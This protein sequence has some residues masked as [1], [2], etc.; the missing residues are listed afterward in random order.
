[1]NTY[2][3]KTFC[4][5][6]LTVVGIHSMGAM[7]K[8]TQK[9]KVRAKRITK[10]S[11]AKRR[12]TG[13]EK[14]TLLDTVEANPHILGNILE[15]LP[16][17]SHHTLACTCRQMNGLIMGKRDG[18]TSKEIALEG[19]LK[20]II[21]EQFDPIGYTLEQAQG[22]P[23]VTLYGYRVKTAALVGRLLNM[24]EC[25]SRV[26]IDYTQIDTDRHH[27]PLYPIALN[28]LPIPEGVTLDTNEQL[29]CR[30]RIWVQN[31]H[32]P[33]NARKE[34]A[35][36]RTPG[37]SSVDKIHSW[38]PAPTLMQACSTHPEASVH[39]QFDNC[40][41]SA[42]T[43]DGCKNFPI[44]SI[45]FRHCRFEEN[46]LAC[47][48]Q[49]KQLQ[50]IIILDSINPAIAIPAQLCRLG[51]LTS[52]TIASHNHLGICTLPAEIC[53]LKR[54]RL[55]DLQGYDVVLPPQLAQ[56]KGTLRALRYNSLRNAAEI[57]QNDQ[58]AAN[59]ALHLLV[60]DDEHDRPS[61]FSGL[62]NLTARG[63]IS[64]ETFA[65][66][67][68]MSSLTWS[69]GDK[70]STALH[71]IPLILG[72]K[73]LKRLII[74][75]SPISWKR[76]IQLANLPIP[77]LSF[78]GNSRESLLAIIA[79]KPFMSGQGIS[80]L[81]DSRSGDIKT[82]L[83]HEMIQ[84]WLRD[85][86]DLAEPLLVCLN[87]E[88]FLRALYSASSGRNIHG[89]IRIAKDKLPNIQVLTK[90]IKELDNHIEEI[91]TLL[92]LMDI[93][94]TTNQAEIIIAR[95]AAIEKTRDK[96]AFEGN[97][98]VIIVSKRVELEKSLATDMFN[99]D[100]ANIASRI[101]STCG[102]RENLCSAIDTPVR[103]LFAQ[104]T[105]Q[106]PGIHAKRIIDI[107]ANY[108]LGYALRRFNLNAAIEALNIGANPNDRLI[109]YALYMPSASFEYNPDNPGHVLEVNTFACFPQSSHDKEILAEILRLMLDHGMD[110]FVKQQDLYANNLHVLHIHKHELLTRVYTIYQLEPKTGNLHDTIELIKQT[111]SLKD[112]IARCKV[113]LQCLQTLLAKL[114]LM[115]N[116][117]FGTAGSLTHPLSF[118]QDELIATIL[119]QPISITQLEH[120]YLNRDQIRSWILEFPQI[121]YLIANVNS[122]LL[123]TLDKAIVALA[124][125]DSSQREYIT[126]IKQNFNHIIGEET[127]DALCHLGLRLHQVIGPDDTI[128]TNSQRLLALFKD[129]NLECDEDRAL[130]I[131][132]QYL[133]YFAVKIGDTSTIAYLTTKPNF[134]INGVV[135]PITGDTLIHIAARQAMSDASKI[136]VLKELVGLNAHIQLPNNAGETVV[137]IAGKLL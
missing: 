34:F 98:D 131:T 53:Q 9:R 110:L 108:L 52:L 124:F 109:D 61:I 43:L 95:K 104:L 116:T 77:T 36:S 113:S 6:F 128:L 25:I 3:C 125:A 115:H 35:E 57:H 100:A 32:E 38:Q 44:I 16:E 94:Q 91:Q 7:D 26:A 8:Q 130:A 90:S 117:L 20:R 22:N 87:H 55:L 31:P 73:T 119:N 122:M 75:Y 132:Q 129:L 114:P 67:P 45:G 70:I 14:P 10:T 66:S 49:L 79:L 80:L 42:A 59:L 127:I 135:D 21:A 85:H 51:Q 23:E 50:H 118:I 107:Y 72:Q 92:K 93:C 88:N 18:C 71:C 137:S 41:I 33:W 78:T 96:D 12:D 1:M 82:E 24:G 89:I 58:I 81:F 74:T 68:H 27:F 13:E 11:P 39:L 136:H 106:V 105:S 19:L 64:P 54:L 60:C 62:H 4:L 133:A 5:L 28:T 86:N 15:F 123:A 112:R 69:G 111:I 47:L 84:L 126:H 99:K 40:A 97:L 48:E 103:S 46:S 76:L 30:A 101:A 37:Y 121:E 102:N 29:S 63:S 134:D 83:N 120:L 2:T 17:Q 65:Q 56:L